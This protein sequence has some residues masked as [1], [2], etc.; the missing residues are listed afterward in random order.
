MSDT[1]S[2]N[3][4]K[5]K[6]TR[7]EDID[8]SGKDGVSPVHSDL[9]R[10]LRY[11][12]DNKDLLKCALTHRSYV[13]ESGDSVH[14]NERLE[15]LG[16]AVLELVISDLLYHKFAKSYSEGDLTKMRA[17]LVSEGRLVGLAKI[18]GIGDHLLMGKGEEK[19]GGRMRPSIL[20]D[21]FE[22]IIGA[23]YLDGG[24]KSAYKFVA[25]QFCTLLKDAPKKGLKIDYKSRLQEMTQKRFHALPSYRLVET[26]GPDHARHFRVALY[27]NDKEISEGTGKSKKEAE[28][29][30]ARIAL[31]IMKEK[32]GEN[33]FR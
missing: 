17:Y 28:Q 30:A 15:F 12:F 21:A 32:I 29:Q 10:A 23:I 9:E 14:D 8:K 7:Q 18:L 22:A 26:G 1:F 2:L 6:C 3:M 27:F 13:P 20:A 4:G 25:E 31:E 33:G 19:C 5:K 11:R 24:F 16:D